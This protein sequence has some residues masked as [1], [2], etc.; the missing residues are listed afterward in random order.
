MKC[1]IIITVVQLCNYVVVNIFFLFAFYLFTRSY[2]YLEGCHLAA[3]LLSRHILCCV[4]YLMSPAVAI[5]L[6][7]VKTI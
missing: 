7:I 6:K 2:R 3:V 4:L 5:G 1:K